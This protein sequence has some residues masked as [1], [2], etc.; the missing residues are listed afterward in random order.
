MNIR[1]L[2]AF[3]LLLSVIGGHAN[4]T[5]YAM[6]ANSNDT[7]ITQYPDGMALTRADQDETLLDVAR[8]F[9]LGQTEIVRLNPDVDPGWLKKVRLFAY[10][11]DVFCRIRL[12]TE[13]L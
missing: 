9:L 1:A 5:T 4:A 6:P 12:I 11:T 7:V 13:L 8:R 3:T 10:P 2:L